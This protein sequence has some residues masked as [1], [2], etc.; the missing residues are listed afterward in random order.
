LTSQKVQNQYAKLSLPIW[1]SSYDDPQVVKTLPEVVA[2]AKTQL[3]D[4]ILRPQIPSYNSASQ[5]LQ[6]SIQKA[7]TGRA[8]PKQALDDAAS[9]IAAP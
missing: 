5:I 1:K 8:S 2:V 6:V 4:M 7:L 9:R 3:N